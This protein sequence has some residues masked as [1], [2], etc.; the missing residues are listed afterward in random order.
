MPFGH[1]NA[2]ASFQSLMNDIFS[3][4]MRKFVLVFFDDILIYSS[5][6]QQHLIHLQLVFYTL[7]KHQLFIRRKKCT[8]ATDN[9]EY[10]GH[11]ISKNGV[12]A[13]DRKV[14]AMKQWPTPATP[15]ALRGFL[16]LTGY[17]RRFLRGYGSIAKP[18]TQLLKKGAFRWDQRAEAAFLQLKEAMSNTPVLAMPDFSKPFTVETDASH[19]GIGAVLMQEGQPLA[20]LSKAL[21][22][23]HL[24]LSTY[25]KELLAVIMATQKWRTYLLGQKFIIKTDHEALKHFMEQKLTTILQQKWL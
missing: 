4:F 6:L 7:K 20:F 1:T 14:E 13:D 15:R 17:Y 19:H 3:D 12:A 23:K 18:L 24:G 10:L 25:E 2:P 5:D 21:S 22:P 16:G 8:F 9:V 11:I